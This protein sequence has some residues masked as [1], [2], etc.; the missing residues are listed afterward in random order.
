MSSELARKTAELGPRDSGSRRGA[1]AQP[2]RNDQDVPGSAPA[3]APWQ[4]PE[5]PS[6]RT[7]L[8][9]GLVVLTFNLPLLHYFLFRGPAPAPVTVP[10]QDDFSNPDTVDRH[11]ASTGGL[12]R[13]E[14][15]RLLSPGVRNNPLWLQARLPRDVAIEFDAVSA[16]PQGDVK[17]ELFG[18]GVDHASGYVLIHGGWNNSLSVIS[19]LDEH[20]VPLSSLQLEAQ[21]RVQ[22]GQAGSGDLVQSG[23]YRAD[24]RTRVEATPFPVQPGRSY[25]WRIVRRGALLSWSID[26]TE[27]MRF[28]DPIPLAGPGHDRFGFSSW[29]SQLFFDNLSI[30]PLN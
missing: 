30:T 20:G 12:W 2:K 29:E 7:V 23:V 22:A 9:L 27:F 24:T 28:D 26:G 18:D 11:Y 25:R 1:T 13:V 14:G 10:Y 8:V 4:A 16:S 21:R 19:R 6:R 17:V 15:G 3:D 5:Y